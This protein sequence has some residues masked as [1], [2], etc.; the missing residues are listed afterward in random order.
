MPYFQSGRARLYYEFD[1]FGHPATILFSSSLG[2]DHTMWDAQ[3]ELL[4]GQFN[5]LRYDTRGHGKSETTPGPYSMELLGNDVLA[6]TAHLN[7][8]NMLFCGLSIGGLTGQWLG[9]HAPKH[10]SHIILCNTAARIGTP[11][12]WDTRIETVRQK[13]LKSMLQ[14]TQDRW[15]TPEF[16]QKSP[17]TVQKVLT[18]FADTDPEG[19]C[20]CCA[21][22]RDADFTEQLG[23]IHTPTL[24]ICGTEDAVTTTDDGTYLQHNIQNAALVALKAAHIS[25]IE[26]AT[27]FSK[28]ILTF[29]SNN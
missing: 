1:H 18:I 2:T 16:V 4:K 20:A 9:I 15:F 17:E 14:A 23:D 19:Y 28:A 6:L 8:N 11:S 22:I 21:A 25:S 13:G 5:I 29:T 3:K 26:Q 27:A 24:I 7:L 10:F 12:G